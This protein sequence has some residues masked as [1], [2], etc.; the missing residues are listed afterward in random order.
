MIVYVDTETGGFSAKRNA[1]LEVAA[2]A[3]RPGPGLIEV[4]RFETGIMRACAGYSVEQ[5]ALNVNGITAEQIEAGACNAESLSRF[6]GWLVSLSSVTE[7]IAGPLELGG[8]NVAFDQRFLEV[9]FDGT[10]DS[11]FGYR[12][13]CTQ[14]LSRGYNIAQGNGLNSKLDTMRK[15]FDISTE[16][17]HRAM[18]DVEDGLAIARRITDAIKVN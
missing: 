5:Q 13:F 11:Y 4:A 7:G 3:V 16:R 2:I 12:K 6:K 17:K 1:L 15:L 10:F 18:V 8:H 14:S 9:W